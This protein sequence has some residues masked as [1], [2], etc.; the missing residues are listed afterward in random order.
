MAF[1]GMQ[2]AVNI[3]L[4][5]SRALL[6]GNR[7]SRR[8][9]RSPGAPPTPAAPA[10]LPSRVPSVNPQNAEGPHAVRALSRRMPQTVPQTVQRR[11]TRPRR[12]SEKALSQKG[13]STHF[14]CLGKNECA[15][16]KLSFAFD[17]KLEKAWLSYTNDA[18]A[19]LLAIRL[20]QRSEIHVLLEFQGSRDEV[21][22]CSCRMGSTVVMCVNNCC[23]KSLHY[24]IAQ[25]ICWFLK[26]KAV[27]G[28]AGVVRHARQ[29]RRR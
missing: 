18:W 1:E 8:A 23:C 22:F 13:N 28:R 4:I 3:W 24:P 25:L 5:K 20:E 12:L 19:L 26:Q 21:G 6:T 9:E 10:Q 7:R 14:K 15:T 17:M 27:S 29:S 16:K 2:P 11:S